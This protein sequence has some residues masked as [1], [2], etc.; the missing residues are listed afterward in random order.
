[1]LEGGGQILRNSAALAAIMRSPLRVDSIRAGAGRLAGAWSSV[2]ALTLS[3]RLMRCP[4]FVPPPSGR[5]TPGLSPQ[6]L[7][8]LRLVESMCGGSLGGG[9]PRSTAISLAPG[10]LACGHYLADTGDRDATLHL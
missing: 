7:T 1:M 6:H 9:W 8:G 2:R 10:Q 5:K 3:V 4:P